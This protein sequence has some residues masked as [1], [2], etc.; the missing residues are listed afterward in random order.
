MLTKTTSDDDDI[1]SKT[2][3]SK[4]RFLLRAQS[5]SETPL[6]CAPPPRAGASFLTES[7]AADGCLKTHT[8]IFFI[9]NLCGR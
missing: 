4:Y 7:T 9:R 3:G 5:S 1:L 6:R 2:S 8:Y